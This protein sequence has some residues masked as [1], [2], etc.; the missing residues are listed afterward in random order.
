MSLFSPIG[1]PEGGMRLPPLGGFGGG[2]GN[3]NTS[4][5]RPA[6]SLSNH[7]SFDS[8]DS[9][10]IVLQTLD[11]VPEE[12]DDLPLS[13][14]VKSPAYPHG[15]VC[16][17]PPSV[18]L[19][20]EPNDT[21]AAKFDVIINVA[22]EV[23]NPFVKPVEEIPEP[24]TRDVGVQVDL[25]TDRMVADKMDID[26]DKAVEPPSAVSEASFQS[27]YEMMS[28]NSSEGP[29]TPKPAKDGPEYIHVPWEHNTKV[30]LELMDLCE[31][32]DDRV[33]RGKRVLI[34]C[35]CGVSRS[36]SLIIA[37]G[38]YKNPDLSDT[39][40][41][42]MVKERSRW[43]NPNMHFIFELHAFKQMLAQ[44]N[45]KNSTIQRPGM[46]SGL[47]RSPTD[48]ALHP[49]N[50]PIT[51]MTG[52]LGYPSSILPGSGFCPGTPPGHGFGFSPELAPQRSEPADHVPGSFPSI[53][54]SAEI[55]PNISSTARHMIWSPI[56]KTSAAP[57][58]I[59][60]TEMTM[61]SPP[62]VRTALAL[63]QK[64]EH[65]ESSNTYSEVEPT[66]VHQESILDS[67]VAPSVSASSTT[68]WKPSLPS[69]P[70]LGSFITPLLRKKSSMPAGF[71]SSLM[72][73]RQGPRLPLQTDFI[74]P[75]P[76]LPPT[77]LTTG[78]V[79]N[80]NVPDS[81]SL[82][83]PRIAEFTATPF[84]RTAAGDLAGTSFF[85]QQALLSPRTIERDPRSPAIKGEAPITRNIDDVL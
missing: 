42:N 5:L 32:I 77:L 57:W 75:V 80:T 17:Y 79:T 33:N 2:F 46:N 37:Y 54:S 53:P 65:E 70:P 30:S 51:P 84:H 4:K 1:A 40:A 67:E 68:F 71:S 66:N 45:G 25:L 15:P 44:R 69:L 47:V 60:D 20:L 10:P 56:E 3:S 55:T 7:T 21:E 63:P 13:R 9:S 38:L 43:I 29:D 73:R 8:S 26:T 61:N 85:E 64:R 36:A 49:N 48:N 76:P 19:Y 52:E 14:E 41:Y 50:W 58:D 16:I 83:S 28:W 18:Y 39:D 6:L 74:P 11:H 23:L 34:H 81:P 35:Q 78:L 59:V 62:P 72:S 82:L 27:A 24:K 22:R 12:G 31:L